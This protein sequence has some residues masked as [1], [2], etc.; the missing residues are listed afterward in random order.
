MTNAPAYSKHSQINDEK[1]QASLKNA[2][3]EHS[4]LFYPNVSDEDKTFYDINTFPLSSF[5]SSLVSPGAN[6]I[7]LFTDVIYDCS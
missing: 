1:K 5:V 4:S 2:L 7:N 3:V 6:G